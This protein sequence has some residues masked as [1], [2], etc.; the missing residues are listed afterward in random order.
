M[1]VE[2]NGTALFSYLAMA[3]TK[4]DG[5]KTKPT[6]VRSSESVLYQVEVLWY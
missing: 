6:A 3:R 1:R 2:Q 4:L 5:T